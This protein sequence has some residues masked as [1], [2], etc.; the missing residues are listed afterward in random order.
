[1]AVLHANVQGVVGHVTSLVAGM[2]INIGSMVNKS[3][4]QFA[5]TV[6]DLDGEPSAELAGRIRELDTVYAV[7]CF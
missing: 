6:L 7:R 5:Y 3:R 2:G 1:M 4:G